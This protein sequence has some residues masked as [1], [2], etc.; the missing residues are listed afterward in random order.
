MKKHF[1]P[2]L[3]IGLLC[4][5]TGRTPFDEGNKVD[6][7]TIHFEDGSTQELSKEQLSEAEYEALSAK[8]TARFDGTDFTFDNY[9]F[10]GER[11]GHSLSGS[12]FMKYGDSSL[13]L[14]TASMDKLEFV[15]VSSNGTNISKQAT[16]GT[17]EGKLDYG[18]YQVIENKNLSFYTD[19]T[20]TQPATFALENENVHTTAAQYTSVNLFKTFYGIGF[21]AVKPSFKGLSV[22]TEQT[23]ETLTDEISHSH[24]LTDKYLVIKE[25]RLSP[26]TSLSGSIQT[27]YVY[28]KGLTEHKDDYYFDS[29]FYFSLKD[30]NLVHG[31]LSYNTADPALKS[32]TL[33]KGEITCD[34][35]TISNSL[36]SKA[37]EGHYKTFLNFDNVGKAN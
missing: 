20:N 29:T 9:I 34:F 5:C 37:I 27:Q 4:S 28:L 35:S 26:L 18:C 36:L 11:I 17:Y 15:A 25:H 6:H 23:G 32:N 31:E 1:L 2:L 24:Y 30:G 22:T 8:L 12:L 14:Y 7:A 3:F 33:M 10:S 13:S 21:L 19:T 16:Y